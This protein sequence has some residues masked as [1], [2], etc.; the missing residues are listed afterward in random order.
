MGL[1]SSYLKLTKLKIN[2]DKTIMLR[3][4]ILGDSENSIMIRLFNFCV[5]EFVEEI[6][7]IVFLQLF[8]LKI[9]ICNYLH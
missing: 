6:L 2:E 5:I 1:V 3:V 9:I 4:T 8:T 7:L